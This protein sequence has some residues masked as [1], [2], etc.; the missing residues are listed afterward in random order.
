MRFYLID[1]LMDYIR[2]ADK[3]RVDLLAYYQ[4]N[5]I[6]GDTESNRSNS[7]VNSKASTGGDWKTST[8]NLFHPS[9]APLLRQIM[10]CGEIVLVI[11]MAWLING[12]ISS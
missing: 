6:Y 5:S 1:L 3:K 2:F 9:S 10:S 12:G 4:P 8:A 7:A 11:G